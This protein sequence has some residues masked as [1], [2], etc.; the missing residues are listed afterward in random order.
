MDIYIA[1]IAGALIGIFITLYKQ[2]KAAAQAE[3]DRQL[4]E[5]YRQNKKDL[6]QNKV[7]IVK[8]TVLL[9][10][11]GARE[12]LSR[13]EVFINLL[14]D[15][16]KNGIHQARIPSEMKSQI[17]VGFAIYEA[18]PHITPEEVFAMEVDTDTKLPAGWQA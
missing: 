18:D 10:F 3:E 5:R 1:I 4:L 2:K 17:N 13:N 7:M 12:G 15:L 9:G 14:S 8:I 16:D 11:H 6:E